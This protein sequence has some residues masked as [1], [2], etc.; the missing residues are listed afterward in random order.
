MLPS[1]QKRLFDFFTVSN[2]IENINDNDEA[3]AQEE[4]FI[5]T[6]EMPLEQLMYLF[7][8]RMNHLNDYCIAGRLRTYPVYV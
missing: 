6:L 3:Q 2:A 4:L 1:L 8:S 5:Q 7:H